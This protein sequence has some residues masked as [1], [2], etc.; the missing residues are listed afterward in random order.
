MKYEKGGAEAAEDT[1]DKDSE[2]DL[3]ANS[4]VFADDECKDKHPFASQNSE[5]TAH[6]EKAEANIATLRADNASLKERNAE[7]KVELKGMVLHS[8]ILFAHLLRRKLQYSTCTL[9]QIL[10]HHHH[11]KK[12]KEVKR[13]MNTRI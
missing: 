10:L 12:K 1:D 5:L 8:V 7:L 9:Q 2:A 6:L 3:V 13:M 4:A 11:Q